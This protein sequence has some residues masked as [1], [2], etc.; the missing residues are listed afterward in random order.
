MPSRGLLIRFTLHEPGYYVADVKVHS[1]RVEEIKA[2]IQTRTEAP[3]I[4]SLNCLEGKE[5][6]EV[7]KPNLK[8]EERNEQ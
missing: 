2:V 5:I 4:M 7:I 8:L 6:F 3:V 1:K